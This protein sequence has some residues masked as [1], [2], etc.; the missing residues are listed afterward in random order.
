MFVEN[1]SAQALSYEPYPKSD[2]H[3]CMEKLSKHELITMNHILMCM[4]DLTNCNDFVHMLFT[5]LQNLLD[6]HECA[7]YTVSEDGTALRLDLSAGDGTKHLPDVIPHSSDLYSAILSGNGSCIQPSKHIQLSLFNHWPDCVFAPIFKQSQLVACLAMA[8]ISTHIGFVEIV[9]A[10]ATRI[11]ELIWSSG[12][13]FRKPQLAP[14]SLP[15]NFYKLTARELEVLNLMAGGLSNK[16][17]AERLYIS[18]ATCK[19]HVENVLAKLEVHSRCSA[20]S[21]WLA[22]SI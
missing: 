6:V 1:R 15:N 17:I 11:I 22:G 16:E 7:L 14:N 3:I 12:A 21:M 13:Q 9:L 20:V 2:I 5:E 8:H 10:Q 19:H 18:V 4:F